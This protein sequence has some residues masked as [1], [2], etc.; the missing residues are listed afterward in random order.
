[1]AVVWLKRC[2]P[3]G[4]VSISAGPALARL[5]AVLDDLR[6]YEATL[7]SIDPRLQAMEIAKVRAEATA[8]V[9]AA[10]QAGARA[11]EEAARSSER[12]ATERAGWEV[13]RTSLRD[14]VEE[15]RAVDAAARERAISAQD[16]L[17]AALAAHCAELDE[18]DLLAARAAAAHEQ[19]ASRLA[20]Q[21]DQSRT[22]ASAAQARAE[23]AD[24][25]AASAEEA[26][27]KA[28]ERAAEAEAS[29]SRLHV[30]VAKEQSAMESANQ[31]ASAAER[32]L[33]QA[34]ADLQAERDRH[35]SSLSRLHEELAELIARKP[36]RRPATKSDSAKKRS[37]PSS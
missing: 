13:E 16:A 34:R 18:R 14:E 25:R 15:L 22:A 29:L 28:T 23:A 4:S 6:G 12:L 21:L 35:D 5:T 24:H 7:R 30:E 10:Q 31:R 20:E 17:E 11:A 19:E 8:D 2:R 1:M 36:T 32:L 27:R 3:Q 33:E 26:A 37:A 9:L